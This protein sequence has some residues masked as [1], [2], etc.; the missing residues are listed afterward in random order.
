MG[1]ECHPRLRWQSYFYCQNATNATETANPRHVTRTALQDAKKGKNAASQFCSCPNQNFK[2]SQ[3]AN[4]SFQKARRR[5][6]GEASHHKARRR[7]NFPKALDLEMAVIPV[8]DKIP[9][10]D[11]LFDCPLNLEIAL[12]MFFTKYETDKPQP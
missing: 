7:L 12:L 4:N 3:L 10:T 11:K 5:R 2:T 6:R 1:F 8:L 9:S